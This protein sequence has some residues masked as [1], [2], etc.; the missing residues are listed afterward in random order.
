MA[1]MPSRQPAASVPGVIPTL[2]FCATVSLQP[3]DISVALILPLLTCR[4]PP[5]LGDA[6]LPFAWHGVC[7][8]Y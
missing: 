5:S 8:A 1:G 4:L 6:L 3:D 2:C 7:L